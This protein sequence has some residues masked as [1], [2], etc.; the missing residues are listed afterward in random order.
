MTLVGAANRR[1]AIQVS[2]RRLSDGMG[3]VFDDES[4]KAIILTF[5]GGRLIVGYT[6]LARVGSFSTIQ[7]LGK[8]LYECVPP[9]FSGLGL[10]TRLAERATHDFS[11]IPDVKAVARVHK[12]LTIL[13]TGFLTTPVGPKPGQALISNWQNFETAIDAPKP[14]IRSDFLPSMERLTGPPLFLRLSA[15]AP[16][17]L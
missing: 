16:P 8:A 1:F 17:K 7:W 9:D 5:D 14:S 15:S 10:V 13:M 12:R 6:G 11:S 3:T 2:D 4:N